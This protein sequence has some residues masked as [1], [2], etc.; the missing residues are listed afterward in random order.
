MI[1]NTVRLDDL[2]IGAPLFTKTEKGVADTVK[3]TYEIG[4][5]HVYYQD[6]R[7]SL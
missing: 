4:K 3:S 2:V 6:I 5:V 7:V 1:K